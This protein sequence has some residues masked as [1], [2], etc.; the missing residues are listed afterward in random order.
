MSGLAEDAIRTLRCDL[1]QRNAAAHPI[2]AGKAHSISAGIASSELRFQNF[3]K[4][5][6]SPAGTRSRSGGTTT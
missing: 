2:P 3:N 6:N 4:E 5:T 1:L